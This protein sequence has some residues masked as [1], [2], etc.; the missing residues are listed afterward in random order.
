MLTGV[1]RESG[2]K[3]SESVSAAGRLVSDT[4]VA[5]GPY[6]GPTEY[7]LGVAEITASLATLGVG[8]AADFDTAIATLGAS[9]IA[10]NSAS[11]AS[12]SAMLYNA[13]DNFKVSSHSD[14]LAIISL[15]EKLQTSIN[16]IVYDLTDDRYWSFPNPVEFAT[17]NGENLFSATSYGYIVVNRTNGV[18]ASE[19]VLTTNTQYTV[20]IYSN[21][22]P[23]S[24]II[25]LRANNYDEE[26]NLI[27]LPSRLTMFTSL[28]NPVDVVLTRRKT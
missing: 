16:N 10:A 24:Y 7:G 12:A 11:I 19:T 25:R 1:I 28:W 15:I 8:L 14:N 23:V 26:H 27:E 3:T 18:P 20:T 4:I 2:D 13:I 22:A 6:L 9:I 17:V 5:E 21:I